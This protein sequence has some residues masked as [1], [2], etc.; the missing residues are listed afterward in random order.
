MNVLKR[1][2]E[3]DCQKPSV[4]LSPPMVKKLI[5]AVKEGGVSVMVQF[6]KSGRM[7]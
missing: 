6:E 3:L 2:G 5:L 7:G 4:N 1:A